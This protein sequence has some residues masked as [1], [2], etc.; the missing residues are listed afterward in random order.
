MGSSWGGNEESNDLLDVED[1]VLESMS[2][3][4]A[5]VQMRRTIIAMLWGWCRRHCSVDSR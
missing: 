2:D 1:S 3:C 5:S 4:A